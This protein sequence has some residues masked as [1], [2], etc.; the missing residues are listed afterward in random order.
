MINQRAWWMVSHDF[1]SHCANSLSANA[2]TQNWHEVTKWEYVSPLCLSIMTTCKKTQ[3]MG[4]RHHA[5]VHTYLS[6]PLVAYTTNIYFSRFWRLTSKIKAFGCLVGALLVFANSS[7]LVVPS[8]GW[9]S[10]LQSLPGRTLIPFMGPS[11]SWPRL[12]IITSQTHW[13]I[14]FLMG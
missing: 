7:L 14:P 8:H 10:K 2:R 4:R 11:S 3:S 12:N 6:K 9:Q 1:R 13:L 5:W